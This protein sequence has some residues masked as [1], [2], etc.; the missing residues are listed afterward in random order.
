MFLKFVGPMASLTKGRFKFEKGKI[1]RVD[2]E[3]MALDMIES[4]RFQQVRDPSAGRAPARKGGV[5]VTVKKPKA[6]DGPDMSE[7]GDMSRDDLLNLPKDDIAQVDEDGD[8]D[9]RP[10]LPAAGFTSKK[11]AV[12]WAKKHL[13][14]D[15]DRN[16]AVT[17]L[18]REVETAYLAKYRSEDA[19]DDGDADTREENTTIEAIPVG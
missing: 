6:D 10:K 8:P 7:R 19:D 4:T 11:A 12:D 5:Q 18:N 17:T 15:L 2:D 14:L 9:A 1:Y 13:D 16:K 3:D